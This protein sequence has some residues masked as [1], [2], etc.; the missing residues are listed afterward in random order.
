MEA[1]CFARFFLA[2]EGIASLAATED[3]EVF[4]QSCMNPKELR[5]HR[6][7]KCEV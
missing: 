2:T 5:D 4:N 3:T 1:A 7:K 6:E